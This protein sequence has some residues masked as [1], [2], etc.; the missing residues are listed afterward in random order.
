[1]GHEA[2]AVEPKTKKARDGN[3]QNLEH[4]TRE[5]VSSQPYKAK[6]THQVILGGMLPDPSPHQASIPPLIMAALDGPV[7]WK[8]SDFLTFIGHIQ[9][10]RKGIPKSVVSYPDYT[11]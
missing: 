11:T 1:M 7:K 5:E 3:S 2:S 10:T 9:G 8:E 6:A 4:L